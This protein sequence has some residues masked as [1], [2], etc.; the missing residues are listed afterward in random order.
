MPLSTR[1]CI[2][3]GKIHAAAITSSAAEL[4]E[5]VGGKTLEP[6][7][8]E[9]QHLQQEEHAVEESVLVSQRQHGLAIQHE[10]QVGFPGPQP[11]TEHGIRPL[12]HAVWAEG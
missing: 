3:K 6:E 1:Q 8:E 7:P 2:F 10:G 4:Y 9:R 11:E 12:R 5:H